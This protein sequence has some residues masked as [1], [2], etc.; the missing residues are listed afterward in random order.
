MEHLPHP[1]AAAAGGPGAGRALTGRFGEMVEEE[2]HPPP[3]GLVALKA[4]RKDPGVVGHQKIAPVQEIRQLRKGVVAPGLR[5]PVH[6]QQAG[7]GPLRRGVLG[8]ELRGQMKV[9]IGKGK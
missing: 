9:E 5:G 7:V 1:E 2:L 3:A 8:D 4:G 6:H